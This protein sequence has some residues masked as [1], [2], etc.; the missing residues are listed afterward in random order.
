MIAEPRLTSEIATRRRLSRRA[1]LKSSGLAGGGLVLWITGC[2][3]PPA[4][5]PANTP[6]PAAQANVTP[7]V[8]AAE[9][10]ATSSN[11]AASSGQAEA[12]ASA[13]RRR[14]LSNDVD[15]WLKVGQD[16]NVTL[17]TGKVEFGQGIQTA[18]A[19]LVAEELNLPF[20]RV[21][22][23][24]GSTDLVPFDMP[25][26]GSQS[27]RNTGPLVRQAG[28]EMRQ[29]L[30]ELGA[31]QLG[32]P[33]DQVSTNNGLV[34]VSGQPDRSVTFAQL[35]AGKRSQRQ[36]SG[37]SPV[38][39]PDQFTVIGQEI[40]RVDVPM[41]VNGTMKYGHDTVLPG[42][43]HGRIL[44]PPSLGATLESVD[45]SEAQ[46]MPG[47]AGVYRDGDFVGLAAE[48]HDQANAALGA[49]KATWNEIHSPHTSE[50]IFDLL[51]TTPDSGRAQPKGDAD[52][53]LANATKRISVTVR[54]PY[55]THA[56]IEPES[57]T[58]QVS[59]DKV[60]VWASTQAPFGLQ[61]AVSRALNRS[62]DEVVVHT[63]M[64]GG[65]FGRK[66]QP[67]AAVEAA[68][69]SNA[70]G[71][72]VRVNWTREEEFQ[73]DRFRP[74]MLIELQTGLDSN[75]NI[76]GWKYDL[77]AAA[78]FAPLGPNP[79][80]AAANAGLDVT[81]FYAV[82]NT[83]AT[84]YQSVSPLPVTFWRANGGP[85]NALARETALDELAE[86]A[87]VDPVTFRERLLANNPRL[88]AVMKAAVQNAGW[89]PGVGHTGQGVGLALD[90]ANGTYV[91][92]V[93][94]V[95]VD[96]QSGAIRVQ[97]IDVAVDCGLVVNPA[98]A[99][100]QIEGGIVGQGVSS[101]LKEQI[102]FAD[103]K[104][105]NN[106]FRAYNPLRMNEAPTVDV[107]FVED[108]SQPMAGLGEPAVCPVSAAI[109]NAVY[110]ATGVRLR[111][112]P[113]TPDRV[114]AALQSRTA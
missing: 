10:P 45:F 46:Q 84:F 47:V 81:Q 51:K 17:Y 71:R 78:Y 85:V 12:A 95:A 13:G 25:T 38:K 87:G 77:Y 58:A 68:R 39:S 64:S 41:K 86:A 27:M 28:A 44:R 104:I 11:A 69:L 72:P 1:F 36:M 21:S 109:S 52:A 35:A 96:Q 80:P 56:P 6:A 15:A 97:H 19:Q 60:E 99:R 70:F 2:S 63:A 98:G 43:L 33:V 29:W 103:G 57:A 108:K 32:V 106:S 49:I 62:I 22:V 73:L 94:R 34:T 40:P 100:S 74:A 91:A 61:D 112:L 111:D 92:E 110:D 65:A 54:A 101:T 90:F 114:Q 23:T 24:M 82:P 7:A 18:F 3:A 9:N 20:E 5:A 55:V 105:T 88:L 31:Q 107:V 30:L 48:K 75:G 4:A 16:G 66:S 59:G 26:V 113:F 67:D 14:A 79:M 93:A 76:A 53:A 42:M 37:Q 8:P 83:R 102:T 89:T 50:T